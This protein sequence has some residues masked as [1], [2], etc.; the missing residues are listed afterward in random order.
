MFQDFF[1][2]DALWFSVPAI[3]GT[4]FFLIRLLLLVFGGI[5]DADVG[6]MEA[7]TDMEVHHGDSGLAAQFLSIQGVTAFFMGFGWSGYFARYGLE[8]DLGATFGV[9]ILGGT[10]FVLLIGSLFKGVRKLEASGTLKIEEATGLE[11]EIYAS[12][13][14]RGRGTG[15]VRLVLR[16]RQRIVNAVS[17]GSALPTRTRVRVASVNSDR[18]V[19]V[20][21]I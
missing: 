16:Q 6:G 14:E 19:T 7:D 10:L 4:A 8:W 17:A 9:A 15:Q 13:P 20:E 5:A 18:T 12:V 21:P 2:G 1:S 11:G 3:A